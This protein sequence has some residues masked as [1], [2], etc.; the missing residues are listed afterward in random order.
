M[1]LYK[2]TIVWALIN[3]RNKGNVLM[4]WFVARL[5]LHQYN[6]DGVLVW[7]SFNKYDGNLEKWFFV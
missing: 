2:L 5:V 3:S 1:L 7:C 4:T 6:I